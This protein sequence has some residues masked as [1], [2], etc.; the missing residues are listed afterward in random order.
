MHPI[1]YTYVEK[2]RNIP[3]KVPK[4]RFIIFLSLV[5]GVLS[6]LAAVLLKNMV[7]LMTQ[8]LTRSLDI[9]SVNFA[10]FAFPFIGLV[11]SVIFVRYILRER[12]SLGITRI[13]YI[14]SKKKSKLKLQDTYSPLI[15]STFTVGSG[16]SVGLESPIVLSGSAI[17]SNIGHFFHLD[18]KT[19]TLLIGC[20]AAGATAGIFSAPVA[21]VLFALEILMIDLTT[22]SIIP[23]LIS[24]VSGT[25]ISWLFLRD[26]AAFSFTVLDPLIIKNLPYYVLLGLIMG[27]VSLYFV[28]A[29]KK[30]ENGMEL[31]GKVYYKYDIRKRKVIKNAIKNQ[32]LGVII[33][34]LIGGTVLGGIVFLLPPLYGEGYEALNLILTGRSDELL[35]SSFFY[36]MR[37]NVYLLITFLILV[38]IF[39]VIAMAITTGSGGVGGMF[40]PSLFV[41]GASGYVIALVFNLFPFISA[42]SKNF[43]VAGMAGVLA[44]VMHAPL[45]AIFLITET[46]GGYSLFLPISLTAAF[47]F[48]VSKLS[49]S[50]SIFTDRLAKRGQLITHNKD[51]AVLTLLQ[52]IDLIETDFIPICVDQNL[53]SLVTNFTQSKRNIFPVLDRTMNLVGIVNIDNFRSLLF[54]V[55]LYDSTK[56][57]DIMDPNIISIEINM[58]MEKVMELFES[59]NSWNL[60]VIDNDKYVGFLSRSR[61]FSAYRNQ[62]QGFY[63]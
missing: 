53:S 62:L 28:K 47:A 41:G 26:G 4:H 14:I 13:L 19:K 44:G 61:I 46:T 15:A 58:H 48:V 60:P 6:G 49:E 36:G 25:A 29:T 45:T 1:I 42:S 10:Y 21:A 18:Y 43:V 56:I 12:N 57:S 31:I 40:A 24:A 51:Q 23:L 32:H 2:I 39:K 38:V 37:G 52:T 55:D 63:D 20:G 33:K 30:I 34:L 5:V 3:T 7:L 9:H 8:I 50:N 59:T 17:G 27:F 22:W 35:N 11:L 16:G 54:E